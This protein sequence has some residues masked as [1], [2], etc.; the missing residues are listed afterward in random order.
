ML[1]L[2]GERIPSEKTIIFPLCHQ[3]ADGSTTSTTEVSHYVSHY[4]EGR[5]NLHT[6]LSGKTIKS[7]KA[8]ARF[9]LK[10]SDATVPAYARARF[11][12]DSN[13]WTYT[14]ERSTYETSYQIFDEVVELSGDFE[15]VG[16][17]LLFRT[18]GT[19]TAF[20]RAELAFLEIVIVE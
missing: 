18:G 4:L 11:S 9:R 20:I 12:V 17:G 14:P 7:V 3:P 16:F 15:F 2:A 5:A 10:T 19:A 1:R 13:G 8:C 6:L